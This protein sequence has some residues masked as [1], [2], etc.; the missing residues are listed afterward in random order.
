[1][2]TD[3]SLV[4]GCGDVD[5]PTTMRSCAKPHQVEPLVASGG[6][7]ALGLD[8]RVLAV[9]CASHMGQDIHVEAVERGLSACGLA[10]EALDNCIGTPEERLRHNCSGNHLGFLANSVHHGWE[11]AGYRHP[12]HPSQDAALAE[13][14]ERARVPVESIAT[15]TDGCGVVA[16]ELPLATIAAMYACLPEELPRQFAAMRAHPELVRGRAVLD[17]ATGSG[18][19]AIAA[20]LTTPDPGFGVVGPGVFAGWL[21]VLV[22]AIAVYAPAFRRQRT[23]AERI[24]AGEEDESGYGG[25]ASIA[26]AWGVVVTAM[27]LTILVLMVWKPTLW[28]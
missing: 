18:L 13:V 9:T 4:A 14:A 3:G 22:L 27:T 21:G 11:T 17:F 5:R 25:A 19:V 12:G 1:V 24:A 6:F 8:D 15:C 10:A 23:L 2:R 20:A 16:F 26:R 28:N 7:D